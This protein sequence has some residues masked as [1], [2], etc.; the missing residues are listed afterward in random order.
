VRHLAIRKLMRY[1]RSMVL[2]VPNF[3]ALNLGISRGDLFVCTFDDE[4]KTLTY[5]A[6]T[7]GGK[8][9]GLDPANADIDVVLMP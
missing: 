2:V 9:P 3:A 1:G 6:Y 5:Q 4:R 8:L 7:V